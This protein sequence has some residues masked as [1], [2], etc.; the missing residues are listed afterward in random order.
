MMTEV[1]AKWEGEVVNG[2]FPLRRLL[3]GSDHSGVF[4]TESTAQNGAAAAIKVIP[5]D[6]VFAETQLSHWQAAAALS[7]PH[8]IRL[9]DAG[10]CRLEDQPFLFVV[11]EYAEQTLAQ[12]LPQRALT[13]DEVGEMLL[14]TLETLAFLHD[15][16]LVQGELKP[17][18]I[19][20]VGDQLKLASD[21]IRAAD[22]PRTGIA[23][24][25]L[26]DPPEAE[27]G[28]ISA[29]GDMWALG[30]TLVEAL[31]QRPP[32]Q[33][34][35][36]SETVAL[37]AGLPAKLG[38][39]LRSCLSRNPADRPTAAGFEARLNGAPPE[40]DDSIPQRPF[41]PVITVIPVITVLIL[42]VALWAGWRL[43]H[44]QPGPQQPAAAPVV[45]VPATAANSAPPQAA[46][47]EPVFRPSQPPAPSSAPA[48]PPAP[49]PPSVDTATSVLHEEIPNVPR[50]AS[51]TIQGRLN[52]AVRVTIDGGGNVVDETLEH[53]GPS[54]YFARLA[55]A[56]ASKWKFAPAA[57]PASRERLLWFEFTRGGTTA[58]AG[59]P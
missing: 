54:K 18:N 27:N 43:F 47:A 22:E 45:S 28:R 8:L 23:K 36:R 35:E 44:R 6:A 50:S 48:P 17:P 31:T 33:L 13:A 51:A 2:A 3:S 14:P 29:A 41:A 4:L 34:S 19:L 37:P 55:T 7:H 20:V 46:A 21:N 32:E 1:W 10:R 25:S 40:H 15:K 26:Y 9:L 49:A 57:D 38:D 42:A 52:V 30:I 59:D 58:R 24:T 39:P 16:N 5:A 53:P 56:A 11:M 12:I